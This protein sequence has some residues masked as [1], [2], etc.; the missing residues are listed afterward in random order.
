M[1]TYS[2]KVRLN[3][4][5][6]AAVN[7]PGG[8]VSVATD[9]VAG[10][11]ATLA[12]IYSPKRTGDMSRSIGTERLYSR[13]TGCAFRVSI[14]VPYAA[15]VLRGTYGPIVG[16]LRR[17]SFGR[18]TGAGTDTRGR[19]V[20]NRNMLAVGKSQGGPI[21]Y[22]HMVSGQTANDFLTDATVEV[23]ARYKI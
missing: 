16:K 4:A 23:L 8:M 2:V 11:I 12:R 15:Y 10:E 9:R 19:S 18:F 5:Q 13:R 17:D 6:L 1:P 22:R 7:Y 14:D 21:T 3:E 20:S